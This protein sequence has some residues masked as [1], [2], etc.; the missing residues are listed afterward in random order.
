LLSAYGMGLADQATLRQAAIE[1]PLASAGAAPAERLD[2]LA[3]EAVAELEARA[4]RGR[5]SSFT[6]AST[7]ATKAP[8]RRSSCRSG[9]RSGADGVRGGYRQRFAF[10]MSERRL[11]VEAVSVEAVGAGD[12]PAESAARARRPAAGAGAGERAHVQRGRWHDAALV[13]RDDARPGR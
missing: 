7:C 8:I 12:A 5:R 4:C 13:E 2:A 3:A 10:L 11:I 6:A 9:R 1:L